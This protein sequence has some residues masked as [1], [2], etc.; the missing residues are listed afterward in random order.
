ML[1]GCV[2][3]HEP[4]YGYDGVYFDQVQSQPRTIL[5][6]NPIFYP[7]RSL[8]FFYFSHFGYPYRWGGS[9]WHGWG[10][11]YSGGHNPYW[12]HPH[13]PLQDHHLIDERLRA[14][15][16]RGRMVRPGTTG[17]FNRPADPRGLGQSALRTQRQGEVRSSRAQRLQSAPRTTA[18]TVPANRSRP[19]TQTRSATIRQP[20]QSRPA[21]RNQSPPIRRSSARPSRQT[22]QTDPR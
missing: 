3:Y 15:D 17:D 20:R 4:R 8:D 5:T 21:P 6:N 9:L 12:Q 14:I 11:T 19:A 10:P 16:A 18:P 13:P 22:R 1:S 7:Y 2:T